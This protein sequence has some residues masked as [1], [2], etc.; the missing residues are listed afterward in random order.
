MH[1]KF[2]GVCT[3][4][5]NAIHVN[6]LLLFL[7]FSLLSDDDISA[8]FRS[9]QIRLMCFMITFFSSFPPPPVLAANIAFHLCMMIT[10]NDFVNAYSPKKNNCVLFSGLINN[11][12]S[13]LWLCCS[14][15][16]F[17]FS[18]VHIFRSVR[19]DPRSSFSKRITFLCASKAISIIFLFSLLHISRPIS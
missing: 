7:S 15:L 14:Q 1:V 2:Q 9:V 12:H 5:A 18:L 8:I 19:S 16:L 17:A 6:G 4:T 11:S 10:C 3:L 13:H